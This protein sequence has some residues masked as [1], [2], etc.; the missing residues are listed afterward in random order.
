MF[1]LII[2]SV[3]KV[4][5]F[6]IFYLYKC[7][8]TWHLHC[9]EHYAPLS[10]QNSYTRIHFKS[11][12]TW[13]NELTSYPSRALMDGSSKDNINLCPTTIQQILKKRMPWRQVSVSSEDFVDS[14]FEPLVNNENETRISFLWS[15]TSKSFDVNKTQCRNHT[16]SIF[17]QNLK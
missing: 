15:E 1:I 8:N 2:E 7:I 9:Y 11:S 12:S 16:I 13:G 14:N 5:S 17:L 10:V 4:F 6:T 3:H